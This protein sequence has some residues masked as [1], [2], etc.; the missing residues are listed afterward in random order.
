M[1][2]YM[3]MRSS[4]FM[5]AVCSASDRSES[6]PRMRSAEDCANPA[7]QNRKSAAVF[8]DFVSIEM[9]GRPAG[10]RSRQ[11]EA[12]PTKGLVTGCGAFAVGAVLLAVQVAGMRRGMEREA[13]QGGHVVAVHPVTQRRRVG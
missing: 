12:C 6:A 9:W 11:D 1:A 2:L 13:L 8:I 4:V 3:A 5:P 10:P 7:Q